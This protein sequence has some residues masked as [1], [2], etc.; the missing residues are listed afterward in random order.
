MKS[1][2]IKGGWKQE[3]HDHIANKLK[4]M[5]IK[6]GRKQERS[7]LHREQDEKHVDQGWLEAGT[8]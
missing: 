3:L 7:W 5:S 2:S 1:V 6:D 8:L 4:S